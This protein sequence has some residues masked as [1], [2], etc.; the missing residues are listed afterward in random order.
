MPLFFLFDLNLEAR[1]EIL[2]KILLFFWEIWRHQKDILGIN[3]RLGLTYAMV[4]P[5]H[6]KMERLIKADFQILGYLGDILEDL[7]HPLT[8]NLGCL[9]RLLRLPV[10]DA[11][12][13]TASEE[14]DF[15]KI[16]AQVQKMRNI[17][18]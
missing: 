4:T 18:L 11:M 17:K 1:A 5:L 12:S 16:F 7:G 13:S 3:W 9:S 10:K 8:D 6:Y 15:Q 2:E 14:R